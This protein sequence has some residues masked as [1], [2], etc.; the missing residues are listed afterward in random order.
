MKAKVCGGKAMS[1]NSKHDISFSLS[2]GVCGREVGTYWNQVNS[3]NSLPILS[4]LASLGPNS[5]PLGFANTEKQCKKQN[6]THI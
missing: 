3:A 2:L 5:G 6:S 4:L 1:N